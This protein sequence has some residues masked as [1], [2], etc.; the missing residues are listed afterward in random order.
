MWCMNTC[1]R[2]C[3]HVH[4]YRSQRR[5]MG[6]FLYHL[7]SYKW[8]KVSLNLFSLGW[9]GWAPGIHLFLISKAGILG[10]TAIL[11]FFMG[12][13]DLDSYPLAFTG[14]ALL[15]SDILPKLHSL[16]LRQALC[17]QARNLYTS[18]VS[19]FPHP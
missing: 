18:P 16:T 2:M 19:V 8:D 14:S 1:K 11:G 7:P 5:M 4:R 9:P 15:C 17:V 12:V 10:V 13:G 3:V 6:D